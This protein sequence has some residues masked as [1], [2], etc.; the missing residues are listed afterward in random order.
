MSASPPPI[1]CAYGVLILVMLDW[2]MP[3]L[4]RPCAETWKLEL[5]SVNLANLP[6]KILSRLRFLVTGIEFRS[7]L[8][9]KKHRISRMSRM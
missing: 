1:V 8:S 3:E 5:H 9:S 2:I 4:L 7:H 6:C